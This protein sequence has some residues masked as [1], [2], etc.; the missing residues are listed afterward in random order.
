MFE[1]V[2]PGRFYHLHYENLV[3]NTEAEMRGLIDD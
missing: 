2:L 3:E 1:Q